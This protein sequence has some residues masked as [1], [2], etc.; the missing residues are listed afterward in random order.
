MPSFIGSASSYWQ[1]IIRKAVAIRLLI[2]RD[3]SIF[4]AGDGAEIMKLD[5]AVVIHIFLR[6]QNK[7]NYGPTDE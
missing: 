7:N 5:Q 2:R 3:A 1:V 4:L 6:R